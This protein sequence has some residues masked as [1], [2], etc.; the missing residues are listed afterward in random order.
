M[1]RHHGKTEQHSGTPHSA[2]G[3]LTVTLAN[4]LKSD[5]DCPEKCG[6]FAKERFRAIKHDGRCV[7]ATWQLNLELKLNASLT[8]FLCAL[9]NVPSFR[10]VS[11]CTMRL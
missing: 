9:Y 8:S 6:I 10:Q 5:E 2:P 7:P 3:K 4:T 11:L 1:V